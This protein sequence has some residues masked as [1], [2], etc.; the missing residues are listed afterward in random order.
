[1]FPP[2]FLIQFNCLQTN[3]QFLGMQFRILH[4]RLDVCNF[5]NTEADLI[6]I[7][8]FLPAYHFGKGEGGVCQP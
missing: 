6:R 2:E 1:M 3:R 7:F 8:S 4:F 5:A